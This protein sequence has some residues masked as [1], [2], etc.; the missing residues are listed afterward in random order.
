V[1]V[2]PGP[3]P[4][5]VS[6]P[7]QIALDTLAPWVCHAQGTIAITS[8]DLDLRRAATAWF[9]PERQCAT[10]SFEPE[11]C[12]A[13]LALLPRD[14]ATV[15]NQSDRIAGS[16]RLAVMASGPLAPWLDRLRSGQTC[17]QGTCLAAALTSRGWRFEPPIPIGDGRTIVFGALARAATLA[18]RPDLVDRFEF[19]LRRSLVG[20]RTRELADR[21]LLRAT[22]GPTAT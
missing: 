7:L 17:L 12:G 14:L 2:S 8:P 4:R 3:T 13:L 16:G 15:V 6:V 5:H 11:T 19:R 18:N 20:P 9:E 22:R 21:I 1:T 10:D